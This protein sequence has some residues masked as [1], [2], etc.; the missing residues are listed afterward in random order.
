MFDLPLD[1]QIT[2]DD[3][4][5]FHQLLLASGAPISEVNTLRKHFSAVK[6][7]RLA[8]A[9]PEAAKVSLL[10]PDVPLRSLDALSSG[11]TSPDHS[12]VADVR[13]LLAKY[14]LASQA[15]A[16]DPCVL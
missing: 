10:V 9:A 7:G 11:P 15:A 4:I 16:F 8:M 2:L 6:G 13:A 12:T 5:A 14:D 1:P 3:T